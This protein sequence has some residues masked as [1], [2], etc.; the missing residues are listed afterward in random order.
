MKARS[1]LLT[2]GVVIPRIAPHNSDARQPDNTS[3]CPP[4]IIVDHFYA[5][6]ALN[7]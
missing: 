7:A 5:S 2:L 1:N 3:N 6:A 4:A